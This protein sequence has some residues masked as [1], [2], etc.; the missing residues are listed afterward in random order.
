VKN[1]DAVAES[2]GPV[3]HRI[4]IGLSRVLINLYFITKE[5][6]QEENDMG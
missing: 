6:T 4:F 2:R 5:A 3:N 1:I